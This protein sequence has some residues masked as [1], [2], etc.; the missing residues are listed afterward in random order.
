MNG[1]ETFGRVRKLLEALD[2]SSPDTDQQVVLNDQLEQIVSMGSAPYTEIVKI[3]RAFEIHTVVAIPAVVAIPTTAAMLSIWNGES[4]IGRSLVIDRVWALRI[5]TT[6]A[7]ASQAALIG[8][9]GQTKIVSLG[10]A[11]GLARNPLNGNGGSDSKSVSYLNAVALDAATGVAAN[12][13]VLPGQT[14]GLKIS[15]GAALVGGDFINAEVNGRIIVPPARAFGIHVMAP[16]VAET[17][18]C[19][20]EFHE[21]KLQ[22]G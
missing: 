9:L 19:G 17:F 14:G 10:A 12:W 13:R 20:I 2:F 11:S 6:T 7:I 3:G 5:A 18:L 22:L 8:A 16:L 1:V 4:D 21:R 15:A